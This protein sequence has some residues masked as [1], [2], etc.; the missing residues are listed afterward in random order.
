MAGSPKIKSLA[1]ANTTGRHNRTMMVSA[2]V[3]M[4]RRP[5]TL[6]VAARARG[7]YPSARAAVIA[8]GMVRVRTAPEWVK[9]WSAPCTQAE[10]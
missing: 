4:A 8:V 1:E 2:A 10:R 7:E 3:Q 5:N 9:Y 6:F